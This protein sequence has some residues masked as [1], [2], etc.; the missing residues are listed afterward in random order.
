MWVA[1][2]PAQLAHSMNHT[3]LREFFLLARPEARDEVVQAIGERAVLPESERTETIIYLDEAHEYADASLEV[4]LNHGRKY[5]AGVVIAHQFL[6]QLDG[7]A[8]QT[9]LSN[10]SVKL[11][12]GLSYKDNQAFAREM[13]SDTDFLASLR[14]QASGTEFALW[15]KNAIPQALRLSVPF[16]LLESAKRLDGDGELALRAHNRDLYCVPN[17]PA[18]L[19]KLAS[20][21]DTTIEPEVE[22]V[23]DIGGRGG[24]QH[25]E[26]QH[27]IR[28]LGHDFG[29][30]VQIEAKCENSA[31]AI[32]VLLVGENTSIAMEVSVTTSAEHELLNLKKCLAE[33][34][35]HIVC[36]APDDAHRIDIQ[37]LCIEV[38]PQSQQA[39]LAFLSPQSLTD[40]LAQFDERESELIRGYEVIARTVQSDP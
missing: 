6:D 19:P 16:G 18:Q 11:V 17:S 35:D 15:V 14:K 33:P 5:K 38:L 37:N 21:A 29:L 22:P 30:G 24:A 27:M 34:V 7:R 10:A 40:Y 1:D 39:R 2:K 32:D 20:E 31:G 8:R 28:S 12:G 13:G 25:K 23:T 3:L 26:L 4:M 9:L 36:V